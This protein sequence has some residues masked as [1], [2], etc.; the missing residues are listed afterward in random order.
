[1]T[2]PALCHH[3]IQGESHFGIAA[4]GIDMRAV[5]AG[6][7][8]RAWANAAGAIPKD[9]GAFQQAGEVINLRLPLALLPERCQASQRFFFGGVSAFFGR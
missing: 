7:V 4:F 5:E 9:Q 3:V 8:G 1:M 6:I 2:G